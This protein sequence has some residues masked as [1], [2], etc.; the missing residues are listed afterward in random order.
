MNS[1][2]IH[3]TTGMIIGQKWPNHQE[4]KQCPRLREGI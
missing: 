4:R 3:W 2:F 1:A